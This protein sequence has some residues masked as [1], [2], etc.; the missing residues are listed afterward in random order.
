MA[1]FVGLYDFDSRDKEELSF[2]K[3]EHLQILNRKYG[4]WW[5][6]RS[7]TTNKSGYIPK[8]YVTPDNNF[9]AEG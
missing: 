4:D 7:L 6:A 8:N 3:G 2:K 9:H 1:V 5:F